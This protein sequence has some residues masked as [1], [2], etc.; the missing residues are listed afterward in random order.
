[1]RKRDFDNMPERNELIFEDIKAQVERFL[2]SS[3][4]TRAAAEQ[5]LQQNRE[6]MRDAERI[7]N[8]NSNPLTRQESPRGH[9][10]S[11]RKKA[12]GL[13]RREA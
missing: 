4:E 8:G 11:N 13:T 5:M 1:M 7:K 10:G 9:N 2:F 12:A 3:E 6:I